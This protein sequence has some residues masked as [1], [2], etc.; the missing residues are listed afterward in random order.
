MI[1]L[2]NGEN[3]LD[4]GSL[5]TTSKLSNKMLLSLTLGKCFYSFAMLDQPGEFACVNLNG[6]QAEFRYIPVNDPDHASENPILS[7][8]EVIWNINRATNIN[9]KGIKFEHTSSGGKDG[10]NWGPQSAVRILNTH[11]ISFDNCQFSHIGKLFQF[12]SCTHIYMIN[13]KTMHSF[14]A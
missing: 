6:G 13:L 8:L 11:D 9:I 7:N 3:L 1:Q 12:L 5:F 2:E 14:Q 4:G 10:Y